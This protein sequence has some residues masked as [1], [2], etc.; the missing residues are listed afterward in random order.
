MSCLQ[1]LLV[2]F[3]FSCK[4]WAVDWF[5]SSWLMLLL[6]FC[7]MSYFFLLLLSWL[8]FLSI[9]LFLVYEFQFRES[10]CF[11]DAYLIA[12]SLFLFCNNFLF[13]LVCFFLSLRLAFLLGVGLLCKPVCVGF[14]IWSMGG[15]GSC[16]PNLGISLLFFLKVFCLDSLCFLELGHP[17]LLLFA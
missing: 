6:L 10:S 9:G 8:A 15:V 17:Y 12:V 3:V 2:M 16:L 5:V 14:V 13:F 11:T 4:L 7:C 1:G